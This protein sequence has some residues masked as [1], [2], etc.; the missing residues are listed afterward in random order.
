VPWTGIDGG[1]DVKIS[2]GRGDWFKDHPTG[3]VSFRYLLKGDPGSRDN[4]MWILGRQD[5]DFF[6]PRHRHNFEQIRLPLR[7][8]M[9]IGNGIVLKEGQIGYFPEGLPYGPQADPLG[10]AKP[11][12]RVQLVL[13]FG[14][15]SGY[16]FMSMEQRKAAWAELQK[17]GKFEGPH[18]L[19]ADGSRQWGLNAVW[20]HVFGTKLRYPKPRYQETV[21]VDPR[22]F[23][24]L[25]L[26]NAPRVE[27]K[28]FGSFTE[29][30]FWMEMMRIGEGATWS[31]EVADARRLVYVLK[32]AGRVAADR[33]GAECALQIEPGEPAAI[34]ATEPLELFII[35][36][37]PVRLPEMS[38]VELDGEEFDPAPTFG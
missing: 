17:N 34:S 3:E 8:D 2:D 38:M 36:L 25:P 7:G 22:Q 37:P 15:S 6:M 1:T 13:Q 35:G 29:R 19:R 10:D 16:G 4:F 28:Y 5:K 9:N 24:W 21:L 14:G 20:E 11:G 23:H 30:A 26:E 32:G 12:E 18:Y 27:R 31:S 33:F